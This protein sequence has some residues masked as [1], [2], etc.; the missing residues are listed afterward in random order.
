ME[1]LEEGAMVEEEKQAQSGPPLEEMTI[2]SPSE[3]VAQDSAAAA[4]AETTDVQPSMGSGS[5][6]P[7]AEKGQS[8]ITL[9]RMPRAG[10]GSKGR[11]TPLICNYFRVHYTSTRDVYHYDVSINPGIANKS[12]CR[13]IMS[14]LHKTYGDEFGQ[15]KFA[16]DGEKSLFTVGPLLNNS[17][18]FKVFLDD[19]RKVSARSGAGRA[20][21]HAVG[22]FGSEE[23]PPSEDEDKKKKRRTSFRREFTV[24]IEFAAIVNMK[25][26]DTLIKSQPAPTAQD[27]L[28][29]LDIVLR[30][31]AAQRDYLLIRES[32][33]HP[34]FGAEGDLGEGVSAWKGFHA[35]FRPTASGLSLNLDISTTTVLK[36]LPVV[37]FLSEYLK[38]DPQ[39]I[40]PEDLVKV[41]RV[42]KG[43]R[44]ETRHTSVKAKISG[45]SEHACSA[46]RFSK[47]VKDES[48]KVMDELDM[49]V[50]E[51]YQTKYQ[52]SLRLP[53]LPCLDCGRSSKPIYLPLELCRI[54]PGQRYTKK[55]TGSQVKKQIDQARQKPE[56]RKALVQNA[57]GNKVNYNSDGLIKE[58]GIK[59]EE[60]MMVVQGRILEAPLLKFG[61]GEEVPRNGRWNLN[62]KTV[63]RGAQIANWVVVSFT[64]MRDQELSNIASQLME[65][66]NRKG[67]RMNQPSGV[68]GENPR[69]QG[70]SAS[71]RVNAM[72]QEL[73][74]KV[75]KPPEF[76][77]CIL[78]EKDSD[79][80]APFKRLFLTKVGI[81][82]QCI[83]PPRP[84]KD[85]YLTNVAL[86]INAKSGGY[87]S[88]LSLEFKQSLGKVSQQ[89]TIIFGMDVSH[90]SPGSDSSS[91][92]AVVGSRD[93]PRIS[94]YAARVRA[95][96][97]KCEMIEGLFE[98]KGLGGMI[99]E[100]LKGFC[101][102]CSKKNALPEQIIIYRDGVSESQFE[103]VL[104][105]ELQAV[106]KTCA[107]IRPT[108]QPKITIIVAQKRHHTRFFPAN[109]SGNVIPG[110]IL[111]R[112]VC[113]PRDYDFFLCSHAG[114]I[115]TTRPTHYYVLYDEIGFSPDELQQ[116][117]NYLCYTYARSTTAVSVVAPIYYAHLAAIR[118][119]N[120][121]EHD[122]GSETSSQLGRSASQ[123]GP[124]VTPLPELHKN[125]QTKMFF[126]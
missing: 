62:N 4:G 56:E 15:K 60:R 36:P 14:K 89:P 1:F 93:W 108:Y 125:M 18:E 2:G 71:D 86:K 44:V 122:G 80:Y 8:K 76:I 32:Y 37:Q 100:L 33:F 11:S 39:R 109:D 110:T 46:Q 35:S 55:L 87:N 22:D 97:P 17:Q 47:K 64:K 88:V 101:D 41:K 103:H 95:Q 112:D 121:A 45:F 69:N 19:D 79:L 126:C 48:G 24:K 107:Y 91:I 92:A 82:N 28:R 116:L 6:G 78:P 52:I 123:E 42:L 23:P 98:D 84:L 31:Y 29:V 99:G 85:Q 67:V 105:I 106:K 63:A 25:A 117:T 54:L 83:V 7:G 50:E 30:E 59:F 119:R 96:S 26:I 10:F 90:G 66:C 81:T 51:Y 77:L 113:H 21:D 72:F 3:V 115:G 49:T 43:V 65:C 20:Q 120:F 70:R 12:L 27:A 40:A 75:N 5:A 16:Y 111:D 53:H 9:R 58:F 73:Q 118:C 74:G 124:V 68:L 61:T 104:Q 13:E 114:I 38:K 102:S 57:M 94:Q 34:S